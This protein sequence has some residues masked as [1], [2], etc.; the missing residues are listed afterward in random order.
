MIPTM[1][2]FGLAF[3]HWW[4]S[5]LAAAAVVWPAMLLNAGVIEFD[6]QVIGAALL[7]AANTGVGVGI[8]QSIAAAVRRLRHRRPAGTIAPL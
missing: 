2:V 3:G 7:G 4:K 1:I 5:A 6:S 8:H